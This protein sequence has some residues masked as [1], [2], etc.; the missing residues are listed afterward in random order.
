MVNISIFYTLMGQ[1]IWGLLPLFWMLL[2]NVPSLYILATRIIWAAIFCYGLIRYKH[3]LPNLQAV[4]TQRS[5]WLY[6]GGACL[7]V[8]LN[9]GTFIYAMTH[10]AIIQTSLAYF[11]SPMVVIFAGALIF[12]EHLGMLQ[13]FSIG[14]AVTGL[15]IAFIL[16]GQI[17]YLALVLCLTWATYGLLKKKITVHSQVSVFI[18]SLSMV[19]L[20]LAFIAFSEYTGTGAYGVLH[21]I[22][23]LLLPATG[24]VTAVPMIFFTAGIKGTPITVSGILM[25]LAPSISLCIGL[26]HG[27]VL[28]TPLL[29]TFVFA[30]IAVAFYIAGLLRIAKKLKETH[31]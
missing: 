2:Q 28:T 24:V 1:I 4:K 22:E 31:I 14:F 15:V 23:W 13:R 19:P 30:W 6:L 18:E 20:S 26:L 12:H 9:W 17:P 11:T 10:G 21:G 7:A 3:L 25:Y 16:Y 29:I 5:Q 27:E 8:T